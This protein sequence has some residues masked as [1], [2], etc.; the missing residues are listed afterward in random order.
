MGAHKFQ[1][2]G[3]SLQT[4]N[5]EDAAAAIKRQVEAKLQE[6]LS[7]H[8]G[9]P[10]EKALLIACFHFS[11]ELFFLKKALG[12]HL[13]GMEAEAKSLLKDLESS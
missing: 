7:S 8:Q 11:E 10:L 13:S 2:L 9:L 12:E 1:C 3:F 5:K 6:A 4:D